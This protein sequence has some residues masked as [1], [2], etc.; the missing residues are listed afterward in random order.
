MNNLNNFT[1]AGNLTSDPHAT[2]NGCI[3]TI[4]VNRDKDTTDFLP[5]SLKGKQAEYIKGKLGKGTG[6]IVNGTVENVT[7]QKSD[8]T[9]ATFF[10]MSPSTILCGHKATLN[11]GCISGNLT[12]DPE[13]RTTPNGK[14]VTTVSIACNRSYKDANGEWQERTS[15]H[16]VVVWERK[17][18]F[19]CN[20]F[21]KGDGIAFTGHFTS[22]SYKDK[23]QNQR[24][25]YELVADDVSFC[26][27]KKAEGD[28]SGYSAAPA[29]PAA[30][31]AQ[32]A[33]AQPAAGYGSYGGYSDSDFEAVADD[34]DLPF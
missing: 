2:K 26:S 5:V 3:F 19:V 8:G 21:R 27:Y 6:V 1:F 13:L 11:N 7:Y 4:A 18:E 33:P 31:V 23:N 9:K 17:A 10:A 32:A 16:N 20:N 34:E 15:F 24:T 28:E 22:R 12:H 29:Q 25:V 30:P 14:K